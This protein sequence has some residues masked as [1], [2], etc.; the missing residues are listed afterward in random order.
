MGSYV[1][2]IWVK[3]GCKLEQMKTGLCCCFLLN[4]F[5][6]NDEQS[7]CTERLAFQYLMR[8]GRAF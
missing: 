7:H 4:G 1:G 5:L 2:F 3:I 8:C 6:G